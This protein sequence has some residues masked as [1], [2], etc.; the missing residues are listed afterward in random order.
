MAQPR[1]G[2]RNGLSNL[3]VA[4]NPETPNTVLS[5]EFMKA[6]LA[7][8]AS[9][10]LH[11]PA[12][13]AISRLQIAFHH[14]QF[15]CNDD[16]SAFLVA[17]FLTHEEHSPFMRRGTQ[18]IE[19]TCSLI[20]RCLP[21]APNGPDSTNDLAT[22]TAAFYALGRHATFAEVSWPPSLEYHGCEAGDAK[23]VWENVVRGVGQR[24]DLSVFIWT[25]MI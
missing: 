20:A 24:I 17:K 15:H 5:S 14:L 19:A 3:V 9:Q 21:T 16:A 13:D 18:S 25:L 6:L 4:F 11:I 7:R 2:P 8:N 10:M 1:R 23:R 22:I 12:A